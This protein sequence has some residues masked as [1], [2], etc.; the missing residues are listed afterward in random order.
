MSVWQNPEAPDAPEFTSVLA[1]QS[2]IIDSGFVHV[3]WGMSKVRCVRGF[4]IYAHANA[5]QDFGSNGIRLGCLISRN[6]AF[7]RACEANSYF[8]CPS[9][10]SDLTSSRIL[11]DDA[12]VRTFLDTNRS[13][14]AEN[15]TKTAQF[16]TDHQ[17]PY[18]KGANAGLFVWVDLFDPVREQVNNALERLVE[19]GTSSEQAAR[20]LETDLQDTLLAKRVF[21]AL[22]ADFGGDV[23]GWFRIVF[24]HDQ[25]YLQLGLDRMIEALDAFRTKLESG[26]MAIAEKLR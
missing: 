24:A 22:G 2:G 18:K 4:P 17:I 12:F 3:L 15:Y 10:L 25:T 7:L 13:R 8:S 21:L 26:Q 11:S 19:T 23:A 1:I 14:L 16:L 9:S 20:A 6:E 5:P